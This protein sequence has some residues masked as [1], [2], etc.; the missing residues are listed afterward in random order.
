MLSL[1]DGV[2]VFG[3]HLN[4]VGGLRL[5]AGAH[6]VLGAQRDEA[7]CEGSWGAHSIVCWVSTAR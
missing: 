7:S 1:L 2:G 3:G 4:H 5:E 6:L